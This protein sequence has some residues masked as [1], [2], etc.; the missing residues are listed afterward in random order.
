MQTATLMLLELVISGQ[1]SFKDFKVATESEW[2]QLSFQVSE[3][4]PTSLP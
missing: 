3:G 1:V 4:L 2:T